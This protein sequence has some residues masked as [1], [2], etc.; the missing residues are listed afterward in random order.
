MR[1]ARSHRR[2]AASV[3]RRV[4]LWVLAGAPWALQARPSVPAEVATEL[5]GLRLLGRGRL[6]FWAMQIY[7]ARLWVDGAF[8]AD[9]FAQ[10]PLA[11]ELEYERN[12]RGELIAQRS[13]QEL[14]RLSDLPAERA[15][16]WL[17][18]MI[19]LFPDVAKND[20]LTAVHRPGRP[21]RFF[22]NA[23]LRGEVAEPEFAERFLAIWLAE[24]T[25][26][27]RL[28]QQLLGAPG[29]TP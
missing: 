21:L 28:R 22:F 11:L 5:P 20:R 7:E 23:R 1:D 6:S 9:T 24:R 26:E 27:P 13:L 15:Q 17:A 2:D 29:L 8:R 25:S 16:R 19:R 18:T 14:Q 12:L 3:S 10:S 4:A